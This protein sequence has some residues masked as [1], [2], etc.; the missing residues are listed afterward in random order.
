MGGLSREVKASSSAQSFAEENKH[1]ADRGNWTVKP[2]RHLQTLKKMLLLLPLLCF[3]TLPPVRGRI[4]GTCLRRAPPA[5]V[6][7]LTT[8]SSLVLT[9]SGEV[10]VNGV[11]VNVS[12]HNLHGGSAPTTRSPV[13]SSTVRIRDT[14]ASHHS[15]TEALSESPEAEPTTSEGPFSTQP[16]RPPSLSRVVMDRDILGENNRGTRRIHAAPLWRWDGRTMGRGHTKQQG[17]SWTYGG[18]SLVLNSVRANDSGNFS[19][20]HRGRQLFTV[21]VVIA[22]P[23]E[24]PTL[25]CYKKSPSSKIRCEWSPQNRFSARPNC[26]LWLSKSRTL[27]YLPHQCSYWTK[28]SRCGCA[29][30]QYEDELRDLHFAYLCVTNV[31]GNV[32]S[33]ILPFIPLNILKPDPPSSV[34]TQPEEGHPTWIKVSWSLP[35][36]WK[37]QDYYV[38]VYEVKY[39]PEMPSYS[40]G[41][42]AFMKD[43]RSYTIMDAIPGV[44]YVIQVRTKEEYDGQWSGWS[45]PVYASGWKEPAETHGYDELFSTVPTYEDEGFSGTG[46]NPIDG[47]SDSPETTV[48]VSH[49]IVWIIVSFLVLSLVVVAFMCSRARFL[50]KLHS[51]AA[52]K[53]FDGSSQPPAAPKDC[54]LVT[55]APP[56]FQEP[57]LDEEEDEEEQTATERTEAIHFNNTT[58]FRIPRE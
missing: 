55:V 28:T 8:G 25:S 37:S 50:L 40:H 2:R 4:E 58:Y 13:P 56:T 1:R 6:L 57:Q 29:V 46:P 49:H 22:D 45:L 34:S 35:V 7:V 10:K 51:L 23:P 43:Q 24:T 42:V 5:G 52:L 39:H 16:V 27:A 19:C 12:H 31:A 14:T 36:S 26:T 44:L 30:D 38:L 32:T 33:P 54:A 11:K 48:E 9:C 17:V 3:L 47:L 18:S 41:Q 20:H 21:K 15:V 53:H